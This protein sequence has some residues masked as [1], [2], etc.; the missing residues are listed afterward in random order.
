MKEEK[1]RERE[2]DK[3]DLANTWVG[4]GYDKIIKYYPEHRRYACVDAQTRHDG[5]SAMCV[6]CAERLGE[7]KKGMTN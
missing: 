6:F 7:V 4:E 1:Q 5:I 2:E 3:T